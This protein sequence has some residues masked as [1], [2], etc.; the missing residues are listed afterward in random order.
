MRTALFALFGLLALA[1]PSLRAEEKLRVIIETDI[2]GD[3]DDQ[4]SFVPFLLYA[5]EWDVEEIIADRPAATFDKDP[6]RDHL[7]LPA[8]NGWE[9][10]QEYVKAYGQVHANL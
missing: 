6:V 3:A 5:N 10:A 7:G 9:L 2:G 4:A 1:P 8:K